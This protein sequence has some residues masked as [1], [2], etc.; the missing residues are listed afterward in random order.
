MFLAIN[1][2]L[3]IISNRV[4]WKMKTA[5]SPAVVE[6]YFIYIRKSEAVSEPAQDA[7]GRHSNRRRRRRKKKGGK[8]RKVTIIGHASHSYIFDELEPA[9]TYEIKVEAF[10]FAG[11][12]PPSRI[13]KRTT[14]PKEEETDTEDAT[15]EVKDDR[16]SGNNGTS[17]PAI[18][19]P[20]SL[21]DNDRVLLYVGIAGGIA[22]VV[23]ALVLFCSV[24]SCLQRAKARKSFA[25]SSS[26][27]SAN[28]PLA[29]AP[30]SNKGYLPSASDASA[31]H[32]KY[33]DTSRS[34]SMSMMS[35]PMA[36]SVDGGQNQR[37]FGGGVDRIQLPPSPSSGSS[38]RLGPNE[39]ETSFLQL[40]NHH[41]NNNVSPSTTT[42]GS[43]AH[44]QTASSNEYSS[45][46]EL[47]RASSAVCR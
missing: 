8:F 36:R 37:Y 22:V 39:A 35:S 34:I 27:G 1:T 23:L 44:A 33:L 18:G 20:S 25:S 31:I 4:G 14:W 6:G 41:H 21:D 7:T 17:S 19:S 42:A 40:H 15:T 16:V 13:S 3:G 26:S 46:V 28:K 30:K 32:E 29:A 24:I 9:T 10:N 47:D 5:V 38:G 11:R 12:S 2:N 43:T 45:N